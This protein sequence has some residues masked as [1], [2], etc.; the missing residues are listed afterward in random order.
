M[1]EILKKDVGLVKARS[2]G[3]SEMAASLCVRP[4]ITTPNYRVLA[5]AFSENHLNPLLTKI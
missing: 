2:L 5:T 4:F 3:F 1:C